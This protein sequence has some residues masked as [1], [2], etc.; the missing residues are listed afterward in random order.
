MCFKCCD[1]DE[2]KFANKQTRILEVFENNVSPFCCGKLTY[3]RVTCEKNYICLT[4]PKSFIVKL[5]HFYGSCVIWKLQ[6]STSSLLPYQQKF[7]HVRSSC[8]HLL[9]SSNWWKAGYTL[10]STV[11]NVPLASGMFGPYVLVW[12]YFA[13]RKCCDPFI[14]GFSHKH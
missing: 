2:L 6:L 4:S 8:T 5:M 9:G 7:D 1:S 14:A 10:T 13:P 12:T 11:R 3:I